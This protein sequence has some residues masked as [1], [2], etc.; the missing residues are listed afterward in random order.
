VTT[1]AGAASPGSANGD[2]AAARFSTPIA[3]ALAPDGLSVYVVDQSNNKVR[4]VARNGT[5]RTLSGGGASGFSSGSAD[6]PPAAALFATPFALTVVSSVAYVCDF[7]NNKLRAVEAN[8]TTWSLAGGGVSGTSAGVA[9]GVGT[10][11]L[12]QALVGVT[13]SSSSFL[14]VAERYRV[15]TLS[16]A[17][18]TVATLAGTTSA[19]NVNGVGT[20]ARFNAIQ[21]IARSPTTGTLY[22]SQ[23][24]DASVRTVNTITRA[25][26]SLVG[27]SQG[28]ADG[29]GAGAFFLTNSGITYD[30]A[31]ARL[32]LADL[33]NQR[34]CSVDPST[35]RVATLFGGLGSGFADGTAATLNNPSSAVAAADGTIFVA[36]QSNHAIRI[37]VPVAA[38]TPSCTPS[39]APTLPGATPAATPTPTPTPTR[40]AA[41]TPSPSPSP[42]RSAPAGS[43]SATPSP[44]ASPSAT[45][46]PS[47]VPSA[48]P[49]PSATPSTGASGEP[50]P[51][52]S[53]SPS[54]PPSPSS[55]PSA[56]ATPTP[57]GDASPSATAGGSASGSASPE[58]ALST[59]TPTP[60]PT[61]TP[62]PAPA[63]SSGGGSASSPTPTPSLDSSSTPTP[64]PGFFGAG[65]AGMAAPPALEP[66]AAAAVGVFGVAAL[67]AGALLA[68]RAARGAARA[69]L[70][71]RGGAEAAAKA[72]ARAAAET[73]VANPLASAVPRAALW[74]L[75][76][77]EIDVW[78]VNATTG[79]SAWELPEGAEVEGSE[80]AEVK[81]P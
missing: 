48:A 31:G 42:A 23:S 16:L 37:A 69:S 24:W 13:F 45:P 35:G 52:P 77:D 62:S 81:V 65:P 55:S 25:V 11:A 7:V 53:P 8:G 1:L 51:S 59:S 19:G 41:A 14:Y 2:G 4:V 3:V 50:T 71:R 70:T 73:A 57:S 33:G 29:A 43:A 66:P 78:Y 17:T 58:A 75:E 46:T 80:A 61:P 40:S 49:T 28:F 21:G 72:A 34:V 26:Q 27:G 74:R 20:G 5:V 12:F 39:S 47:G 56:S 22:V 54:L 36:D 6:G 38:G 67:A 32:I 44:P 64:S 18:N 10:A 9:D 15:R 63:S 79:E 30:E 76:R 68:A 60:T